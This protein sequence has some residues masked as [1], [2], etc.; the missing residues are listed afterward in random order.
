MTVY[1]IYARIPTKIY[2]KLPQ[3]IVN[4]KYD[5]K[6]DVFY[7]IWGFTKERELAKRL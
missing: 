6:N 7:G 1:F 2:Q 5:V 3:Q 4:F